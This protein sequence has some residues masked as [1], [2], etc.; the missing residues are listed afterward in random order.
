[1]KNKL[2]TAAVASMIALSG[3]PVLAKMKLI[4]GTE[5]SQRVDQLTKEIS[6]YHNLGQA[7]ATARKNGKMIFWVQ[8]LGD[9]A[10]AT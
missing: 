9:M 3:I 4:G 5:A 7:E 6:W 2:I 1:V 8:M 10:G